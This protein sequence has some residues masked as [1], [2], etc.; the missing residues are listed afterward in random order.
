MVDIKVSSTSYGL[1]DAIINSSFDGLFVCDTEATVVRMNPA[2]EKIH[3]VQA[4]QVVGK[5][6]RVLIEEGF[7]DRSAALE[8]CQTGK[9]TSMLQQKNGR[10]SCR[11]RRPCVMVLG[12]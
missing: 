12:T 1:L 6:V 3:Q 11:W 9:E 5:N 8:T 2:S 10:K 4:D 7:I